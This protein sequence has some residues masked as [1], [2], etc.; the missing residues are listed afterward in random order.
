MMKSK[1][2][3]VVWGVLFLIC[4]MKLTKTYLS[5]DDLSFKANASQSPLVLDLRNEYEANRA[6]DR[7]KAT[8]MRTA[9]IGTRALHKTTW[10]KVDLGGVY[11]IYDINIVFKNY[12][13]FGMKTLK[14]VV[15][16][17]TINRDII[18]VHQLHC[19]GRLVNATNHEMHKTFSLKAGRGLVKCMNI[20]R[21]FSNGT[22]LYLSSPTPENW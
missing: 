15:F 5:A 7:N 14:V 1:N 17:K 11:S 13:Q 22:V 12:E 10:W 16:F 4:F 19:I 9:D 18:L 8:C 2:K 6:L 3:C 20:K 21:K